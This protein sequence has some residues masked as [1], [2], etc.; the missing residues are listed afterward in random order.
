VASG[1]L[2]DVSFLEYFYQSGAT[3]LLP[4][5]G[6]YFNA[7]L[8]DP[9]SVPNSADNH[10][11]RHYEEIRALMLNN[12]HQQGI[13]WITGFTWPSPGQSHS[14]TEEALP[15]TV[16]SQAEWLYK[17]YSLL[18]GQLYIGAAFFSWLNPPAGDHPNQNSLFLPDSSLHPA[19]AQLHTLINDTNIS[20]TNLAIPDNSPSMPPPES[21]VSDSIQGEDSLVLV[22]Y[23]NKIDLKHFQP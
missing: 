17:A 15:A 5:I 21:V 8:G 4:V 1:D 2:E 20:A 7:M 9:M 11:L 6:I 10:F 13:I 3:D 14:S 19:G 18:K 16:E 12:N 23:S 22:K